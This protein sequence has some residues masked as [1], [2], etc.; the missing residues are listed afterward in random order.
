MKESKPEELLQAW[1]NL[2]EKQRN[3]MD[4]ILQDI[5]ELDAKKNLLPS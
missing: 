5:F 4:A 1:L 3:D 2:P